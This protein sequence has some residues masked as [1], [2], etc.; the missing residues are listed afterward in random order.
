MIALADDRA[1]R[2]TLNVFSLLSRWCAGEGRSAAVD[3]RLIDGA[4]SNDPVR[5]HF[6]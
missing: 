2:Q 3:R 6:V 1:G 5:F 4:A